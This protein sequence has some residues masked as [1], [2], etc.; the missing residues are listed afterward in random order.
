M[1]SLRTELFK[2]VMKHDWNK[3]ID[4]YEKYPWAHTLTITSSGQTALHI[5]ISD[6]EYEDKV[7]NVKKL[8][9]HI[10]THSDPFEVLQL[11]TEKGHT[12]LHL[13]AATGQKGRMC[14]ICIE[15]VGDVKKAS[16]LVFLET[17]LFMAVHY[18]RLGSFLYLHS[19][20]GNTGGD[21]SFCVRDDGQSILHDAI[22][23]ENF[24]LA[25]H[26]IHLFKGLVNLDDHQGDTPLHALARK[27]AAFESGC[28]LRGRDRL[29]YNCISVEK[30]KPR[31]QDVEN[32]AESSHLEK[33]TVEFG[34][35]ETK[36]TLI[37]LESGPN[38]AQE[39][40][41]LICSSNTSC[42]GYFANFLCMKMP[43]VLGYGYMAVTKIYAEKKKHVWADQVL[44]GLL[45]YAPMYDK[46]HHVLEPGQRQK[47]KEKLLKADQV[48]NEFK[49]RV[50]RAGQRK[51]SG[52]SDEGSDGD[53]IGDSEEE[54]GDDN[55]ES[56]R[57]ELS[58][59]SSMNAAGKG[60]FLKEKRETAILVAAKYG[61]CEMV[62]KI[63]ESFPVAIYDEDKDRKNVLLVAVEKRHLKIYKLLI[64]KYPKRSIVFQ[65]VDKKGNT[66]LHFAATYDKSVRPWPVPGAALQ[67]QWEIKWHEYVENTMPSRLLLRTNTEG[68]TPREIF[69]STH[70][71][72]VKA[73]GEWLISMATSCSVV[74]ALI[75]TIAFSSSTTVPGGTDSNTGKPTLRNNPTFDL[76]AIASLVAL[77]FSVT[78]MITFLAILTSR[79]QEK[80]FGKKLPSKILMGLTS[81]FVSIATML[82]TFCAGH[83]LVFE[84]K[85]KYAAFPIYAVTFIPLCL[86]AAAQFPLYFDLF[87]STFWSPF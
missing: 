1:E 43:F 45:K 59:S 56:S 11:Q 10:K 26:I 70:E 75:V 15:S 13:A 74:A 17:P 60:E 36:P 55:S 44:N 72:L 22:I 86:F 48:F 8:V 7:K 23:R 71:P 63:I 65:K 73:G 53:L 82:V 20:L 19:I 40:H 25:F 47:V 87:Q 31:E 46:K 28:T 32:V 69:S 5:A 66:A 51:K 58:S 83:F 24:D 68:E 49:D 9:E 39:N 85:F 34:H 42:F 21:L 64:E 4:I 84:D 62:K 61:I 50:L 33:N 29:I 12:P 81:L 30:L 38:I 35:A 27:A 80:D 77:C 3:V 78:S 54:F 18:G 57:M 37:D 67:M 16:S 41:H 52:I 79:H 76:F 2:N 6:P 14:R